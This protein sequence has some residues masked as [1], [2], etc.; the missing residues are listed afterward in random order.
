MRNFWTLVR[1]EHKKLLGKKSAWIAIGIAIVLILFANMSNLFGP[2]SSSYAVKEMTNYEAT[3]YYKQLALQLSGEELDEELILEVSA[4][5]DYLIEAGVYAAGD[6]VSDIS[7][8]KEYAE[9]VAPYGNV[10]SRMGFIYGIDL[11][12]ITE[13]EASEFYNLGHEKIVANVE[14]SPFYTEEEV[15]RILALEE[16]IQTPYILEYTA[17]YSNFFASNTTTIV[18]VLLLTIFLVSPIFS[19]EQKD[20]TD[21]LILTTGRGKSSLI[22]AKIFTAVSIAV[23]V[24]GGLLLV[25]IGTLA[26]IYGFEGAQGVIQLLFPTL[27][28]NFTVLDTAAVLVV[29]TLFAAIFQSAICSVLSAATKNPLIPMIVGFILILAGSMGNPSALP[30]VFAKLRCFLPQTMG[31]FWDVVGTQFSW[32]IFG[33][34]IW[35]YQAVC[36]VAVIASAALFAISYRIFKNHQVG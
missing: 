27:T 19:R 12:G 16:G 7:E 20:R 9:Q 10:I 22:S 15:E 34:T 23:M 25:A 32:S 21:A 13:Q 5:Y 36:I 35:L 24:S 31:T 6:N 11:S 26:A 14:N 30:M 1:Y 4:A 17:G 28:Y 29:A 33:V 18:M 3:Q 2:T 8:A